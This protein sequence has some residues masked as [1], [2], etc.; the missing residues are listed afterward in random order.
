MK[1]GEDKT[2]FEKRLEAAVT[3]KMNEKINE[4]I[5]QEVIKHCIG[6]GLITKDD[7]TSKLKKQLD[8][9][10]NIHL[11]AL[12]LLNAIDDKQVVLTSIEEYRQIKK[13]KF[14]FI[15]Q[16]IAKKLIAS[17]SF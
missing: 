1:L 3:L 15:I 10:I 16:D 9:L 11:G 7:E 6:V 8:V 5:Y 14:E 13:L 17:I 12:D 2:I 4:V